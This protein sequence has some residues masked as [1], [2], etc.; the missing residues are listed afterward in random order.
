[1]W[2]DTVWKATILG[3]LYIGVPL[4]LHFMSFLPIR[5]DI[6]SWNLPQVRQR[7]NYSTQSISWLLM[8]TWLKEPGNQQPLY[9][10]AQNEITLKFLQRLPVGTLL[11]LWANCIIWNEPISIIAWWL[12][13]LQLPVFLCLQLEVRAEFWFLWCQFFTKMVELFILMLWN[14]LLWINDYFIS[15]EVNCYGYITTSES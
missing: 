2:W 10:P 1:M 5:Y 11:A 4:Y 7:P 13:V 9:S 6:G 14:K 12:F 8:S 15:T 3:G